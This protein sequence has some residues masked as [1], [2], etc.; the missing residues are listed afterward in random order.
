MVMTNDSNSSFDLYPL[1][2][3]T[4]ATQL[5]CH[6]ISYMELVLPV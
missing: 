3:V 4:L 1:A 2:V 5:K 6:T